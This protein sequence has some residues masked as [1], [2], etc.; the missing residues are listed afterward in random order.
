MIAR[1]AQCLFCGCVLDEVS[2]GCPICH[3]DTEVPEHVKEEWAIAHLRGI[4]LH[5]GKDDAVVREASLWEENPFL[6]E[7]ARP[8]LLRMEAD[9]EIERF[10]GYYRVRARHD[11]SF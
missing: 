6:E 11:A 2:G 4:I 10:G 1:R 5:L 9:G 3:P 8:L 7:D